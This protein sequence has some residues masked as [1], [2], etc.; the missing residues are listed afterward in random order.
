MH[1]SLTRLPIVLHRLFTDSTPTLVLSS[2]SD[3]DRM[4]STSP[5]SSPTHKSRPVVRTKQMFNLEDSRDA[6][7]REILGQSHIAYSGSF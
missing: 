7:E 4:Q 6:A 3:A 2:A 1:V 5:H